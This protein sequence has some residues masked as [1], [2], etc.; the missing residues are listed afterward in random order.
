MTS[1][2]TPKV[3]ERVSSGYTSVCYIVSSATAA[4]ETDEILLRCSQRLRDSNNGGVGFQPLSLAEF[5][6]VY[7]FLTLWKK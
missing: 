5:E 4:P 2:Y 3:Y 7:L 1:Q 6:L